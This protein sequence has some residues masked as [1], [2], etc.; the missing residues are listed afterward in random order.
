[1]PNANYQRNIDELEKHAV[2][3]WPLSLMQREGATSIAPKLLETLEDFM[4][5]L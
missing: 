2:Q 4:A 1:M 5:V 3:W